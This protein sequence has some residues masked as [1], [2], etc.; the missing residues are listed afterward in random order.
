M[1]I[2]IV[3]G[4]GT[5]GGRL[6]ELIEDD[7]RLTLL[8]SGRSLE[9]ARQYCAGRS[10]ALAALI[11]TLFDRNGTSHELQALR[12]DLVVDASG[13]FQAYGQKMYNLIERCLECRTNYVDLADGSEFV[14]GVPGF[15]AAAK[16]AGVFILTGASSFPVLT[17]AVVRRLSTDMT[18]VRSIRGGIAPSAFAGVG[19]NVIRAIASYAGQRV[20]IRRNGSSAEGRPFTESIP[21]V[22]CVPGRV[23]LEWRRFSLVDVPDLRML[24]T[25]WPTV[26]EVW[27]GAAPVPGMLHRLLNAF[28]WLVRSRVLPTLSWMAG[29]MHF[30]TEHAQWGEHRGGMFVE[31][32]GTRSDGGEVERVWNLL[33]EGNDGPLIPCMAV[34][35]LIR[36]LV[37]GTKP[38]TGAR[39]AIS[40]VGLED[41]E[42]LFQRRTVYTG[43]R[44]MQGGS[45][46]PL[47]RR[48]L[49]ESWQHLAAPIQELHTVTSPR[50]FSGRCTVRRGR[51]LLG[52]II[53]RI[54]GF[55]K[56]GTDMPITVRLEPNGDGERW[57]RTC[58]GR[59]FSSVQRAGRG[60]S[61]WLL[62]ER[63]G[64]VSVDTA[65]RLEGTHLRYS[66]RRWALLGI[67]LPLRW[68]PRS[69][70]LESVQDGLFKFDVEVSLPVAGLIVHYTGTLS[71]TVS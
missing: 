22:I 2:L 70:A 45:A 25:L 67:P 8:V 32:V 66:V 46:M 20:A 55:P 30:V 17:A 27:M 47:F 49:G 68:G 34:E 33:A 14:A 9:R 36:K 23:P 24:P 52:Q 48:V 1:R 38:A 51:S 37:A 28:A 44:E 53:A 7:R 12:P 58:S 13:P 56:A 16:A 3:G 10:K 65:L 63:F 35:A 54:T 5:F 50:C 40:D 60:R 31:V 19:S 43:T 41:Y 42:A 64:L 62:R 4:Y 29:A 11:P 61:Q 69:N 26:K 15:D 18:E 57:S 71:P 59:T 21:Y 6:V 39:S